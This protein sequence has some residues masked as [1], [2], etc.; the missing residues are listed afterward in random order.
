MVFR[1]PFSV[2]ILVKGGVERLAGQPVVLPVAALLE[3]IG[4][5]R[6]HLYTAF[7]SGRAKESV[8]GRRAM[9]IARVTLAGLSGV[10]A[11]SQRAYEKQTKQGV[12]ANFAVGEVVTEENRA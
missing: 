12:Q 5:F 8:C 4:S 1:W 11:P 10:G 3:G 7:H 2:L 9:P 6:V